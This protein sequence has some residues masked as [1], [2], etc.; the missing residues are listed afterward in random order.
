MLYRS[1]YAPGLVAANAHRYPFMNASP[2][3]VSNRCAP[4]IVQHLS[5]ESGCLPRISP[6]FAKIPDRIPA[7]VKNIRAKQ[8]RGLSRP[9]KRKD[10]LVRK[11]VVPQAT[12][13]KIKD[14]IIAKQS[15]SGDNR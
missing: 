7:A 3:H 1:K 4:E 15:V 9:Y 8:G 5:P 6:R 14:Q 13:D 2:N 10:E 11:K 12:Y